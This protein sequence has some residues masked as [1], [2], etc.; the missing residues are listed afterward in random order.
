[1]AIMNAIAYRKLYTK[2]MKVKA[3]SPGEATYTKNK[4]ELDALFTEENLYFDGFHEQ[5][6]WIGYNNGS[7]LGWPLAPYIDRKWTVLEISG[8]IQ[9]PSSEGCQFRIYIDDD[10]YLML[11]G[12]IV[13]EMYG[14]NTTGGGII[15]DSANLPAGPIEIFFRGGE[16]FN[17]GLGI[18][19]QWKLPG[20]TDFVDISEDYFLG[21]LN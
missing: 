18:R 9:I 4:S 14:G 16:T 10:C 5:S 12:E 8:F 15:I 3:Y 17:S 7:Y 2:R 19:I 1:M 11:N 6:L 20:Q 21:P 13:L